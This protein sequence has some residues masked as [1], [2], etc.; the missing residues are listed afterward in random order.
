MNAN[1]MY[2]YVE[3]IANLIRTSV[4]KD[5]LASG[6]QPVQMERSIT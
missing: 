4:R 1:E 6:L 3:R 2:E 5:G